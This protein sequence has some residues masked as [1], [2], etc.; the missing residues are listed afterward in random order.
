MTSFRRSKSLL[1]HAPEDQVFEH[2]Y[3]DNTVYFITA[4][5]A[6]RF[7]AFASEQ[8]KQIFWSK[9]TQYTTQHHFVPWVTSLLDNHYHTLGYLKS[10]PEL[11]SMMRKLHGSIAKLTNDL[12][13]LRLVPFWKDHEHHDYFDGC[14]RDEKQARLAYRYTLNQSV[15]HGICKDWRQYPHTRV[16]VDL[17]RAVKRALELKAFMTGVCYKRYEKPR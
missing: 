6:D 3:R 4:R 10:G 15:R 17:E 12:L 5:C 8:A 11:D 13:L 7:P 14:I 2:W 9:F 16:N 1:F